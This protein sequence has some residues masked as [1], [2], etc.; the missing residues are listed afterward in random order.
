MDGIGKISR[1]QTILS[2]HR[3]V[4]MLLVVTLILFS[5][6]ANAQVTCWSIFKAIS[7]KPAVF[8]GKGIVHGLKANFYLPVAFPMGVARQAPKDFR[9]GGW[10]QIWKSPFKTL[11]KDKFHL[12]AYLLLAG[13]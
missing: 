2:S 3:R 11:W 13:L 7:I 9:Q 5:S 8:T 10:E 6:A 4:A 12:T 1:F